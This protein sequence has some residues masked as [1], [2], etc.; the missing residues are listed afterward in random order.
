MDFYLVRHGDAVLDTL[1]PQ[2]P[3]SR[4]GQ[5]QVEQVARAAAARQ[6]QVS[7][8]FHSG[9]LRAQQTAEILAAHLGPA[10]GVQRM[11]GL[12]PQDDP[13]IAKA[14]LEAAPAPVM[15][16][17]HLPHMGRL[18]GLLINGDADRDAV[19]FAPATIVCISRESSLWQLVWLLG[20]DF[21]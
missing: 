1:D 14:E 12:A 3:L 18:A 5:E 6:A 2:R 15:L 7:A 11:S 9:I 10:L 19:G 8:I 4:L 16:V 21:S 17:G 20:P 13:A